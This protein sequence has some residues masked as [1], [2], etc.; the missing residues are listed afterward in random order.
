VVLDDKDGTTVFSEARASLARALTLAEV[1]GLAPARALRQAPETSG[2]SL[3]EFLLGLIPVTL[4]L[5]GAV[6]L[7]KAQ[8]DRI[9]CAHLVFEKTHEQMIKGETPLSGP[10]G[11]SGDAIVAET[12]TGFIGKAVCG[13]SRE[14]VELPK[15]EN[16]KW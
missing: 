7:L 13:N 15:L 5:A 4:V 10:I 8:W 11:I 12:P 2:Q 14:R 3:V 16:A 6:I 1:P 9:R